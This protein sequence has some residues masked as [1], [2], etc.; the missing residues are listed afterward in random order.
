[1]KFVMR[2]RRKRYL[3]QTH[4]DRRRQCC[5]WWVSIDGCFKAP[6]ELHWQPRS[7]PASLGNLCSNISI[8]KA[9]IISTMEYNTSLLGHNISMI[10]WSTYNIYLTRSSYISLILNRLNASMHNVTR[11]I[12]KIVQHSLYFASF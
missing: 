9:G 4:I 11:K 3:C 12:I 5:R 8:I 10:A 2:S 7:P 1:M 6:W